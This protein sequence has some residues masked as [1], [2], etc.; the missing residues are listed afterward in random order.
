[1]PLRAVAVG[2]S[3]AGIYSH[4]LHPAPDHA[5]E[6]VGIGVVSS[7]VSPSIHNGHKDTKT[8]FTTDYSKG[9]LRFLLQL[10]I[11]VER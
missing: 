9:I 5:P 2:A 7:V 4:L 3:E 10:S 11:F 6:M 1:M 8:S